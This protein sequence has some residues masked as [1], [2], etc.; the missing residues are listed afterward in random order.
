MKWSKVK[1]IPDSTW[2]LLQ[3]YY[4][5]VHAI[6]RWAKDTADNFYELRSFVLSHLSESKAQLQQ[7]L[8]ALYFNSIFQRAENPERRPFFVEIGALDGVTLSNTLLLEKSYGWQG[9]LCEADEQ[10]FNRL[11]INRRLAKLDSR[12]ASRF[13]GQNLPFL[14]VPNSAFSALEGYSTH[15]EHMSPT[16]IKYVSTVN[17]TDLLD[18]HDCP[19]NIEF[20]SIDTEGNEFEILQGVDFEKY[21]FNYIAVEENSNKKQLGNL[22]AGNGYKRILRRVSAWDSWWVHDKVLHSCFTRNYR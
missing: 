10:N 20:L 2:R 1:F 8:V 6:F 14:S 18:E 17:L 22:L 5:D 15:I 13:S 4:P 21:T 3:E 11:K 7:D 16:Q 9:L 19:V 12:A